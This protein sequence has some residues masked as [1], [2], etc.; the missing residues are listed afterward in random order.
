MK[1][2]FLDY[3]VVNE[4]HFAAYQ[5]AIRRVLESGWYILGKEVEAFE[6][7]YAAYVG[8]PYCVGVANGLDALILILEGY[9]AMGLMRD[10]DEVIVPSNT[11]IASI[12]AVSRG[13]TDA[14]ARGAGSLNI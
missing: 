8:T 3:R 14:G 5:D 13:R 2:P 9:K 7:E 6:A 1:V 12:L 10:G 4:P 11:Y